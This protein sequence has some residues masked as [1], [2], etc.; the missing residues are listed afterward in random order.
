VLVPTTESAFFLDGIGISLAQQIEHAVIGLIASVTLVQAPSQ[1]LCCFQPITRLQED[2]IEAQKLLRLLA[3]VG[4]SSIAFYDARKLLQQ[5]SHGDEVL[6]AVDFSA[7]V[8]SAQYLVPRRRQEPYDVIEFFIGQ[9]LVV[10]AMMKR[11]K[12]IDSRINL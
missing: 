7:S 3:H 10:M 1:M 4:Q 9:K 12:V 5:Q 11:S 8:Q 2:L 6:S